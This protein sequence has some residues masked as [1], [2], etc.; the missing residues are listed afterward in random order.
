MLEKKPFKPQSAMTSLASAKA[1]MSSSV[2][3]RSD[4][5]GSFNAAMHVSAARLFSGIALSLL[6]LYTRMA[7]WPLV[8]AAEASMFCVM[9]YWLMRLFMLCTSDGASAGS[10]EKALTTSASGIAYVCIMSPFMVTVFATVARGFCQM[11]ALDGCS[12]YFLHPLFCLARLLY[13]M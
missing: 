2:T 11:P 10:G 6:S 7:I 13:I 9:R 12:Q 5:A 3:A 8:I 4:N 1:D